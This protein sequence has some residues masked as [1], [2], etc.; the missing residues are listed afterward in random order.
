MS[1]LPSPSKSPAPLMCKLAPGLLPGRVGLDAGREW[2][3]NHWPGVPESVGM[4]ATAMLEAAADGRIETLILLGSDPLT[5]F[6]DRDLA[7][8]A[9]AG[10][11]TVI[12]IDQFLTESPRYQARP[13][14]S[15]VGSARS[16]SA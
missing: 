1:D 9:L 13:R 11:R 16:I 10:A 7:T 4:D 12:A 15:K 2:F 6:P 3:A 5:D 14:T 8:R